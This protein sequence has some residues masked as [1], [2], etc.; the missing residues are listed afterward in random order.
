MGWGSLF[1]Y[2]MNLF[3]LMDLI[4]EGLSH[5]TPQGSMGTLAFTCPQNIL[6]L[7]VLLKGKYGQS[8]SQTRAPRQ[9]KEMKRT[10]NDNMTPPSWRLGNHL[11]RAEYR[12]Q[13][14]L[15]ALLRH[16]NPYPHQNKQL[17]I[18]GIL[19]LH[20]YQSMAAY[21]PMLFTKSLHH[22]LVR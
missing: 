15:Q 17:E 2:Y 11:P 18:V 1:T 21:E 7:L 8:T 16:L 12:L 4:C 13:G 14:P 5:K 22:T 10:C 3:N 19:D 20:Y 9:I 6:R